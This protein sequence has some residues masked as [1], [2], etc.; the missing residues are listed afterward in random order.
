MIRT[1]FRNRTVFIVSRR[2]DHIIDAERI[3]VMNEGRL[4]E[5]GHPYKLLVQKDDDRTITNINGNFA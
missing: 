3:M 1:R 5:F 4:T 2:L